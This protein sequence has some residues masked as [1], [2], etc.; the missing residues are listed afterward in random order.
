[1]PAFVKCPEKSEVVLIFLKLV[2][3]MWNSSLLWGVA[4]HVTAMKSPE[5][6]LKSLLLCVELYPHEI[7]E[8][9]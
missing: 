2:H 6:A 7:F 8:L 4:G 9:S 1:M 5:R 3:N